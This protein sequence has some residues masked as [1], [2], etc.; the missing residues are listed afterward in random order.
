M[1]LHA[2]YVGSNQAMYLEI[3]EEKLKA[4]GVCNFEDP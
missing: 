2:D 4:L 3:L 1:L